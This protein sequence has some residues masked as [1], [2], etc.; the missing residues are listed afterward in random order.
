V[1]IFGG[2][3]GTAGAGVSRGAG[4]RPVVGLQSGEHY[5]RSTEREGYRNGTAGGYV[6]VGGRKVQVRRPRLCTVD[7][8]DIPLVSYPALQDAS[9]LNEAA[10]G[11]VIDGVAQRQAQESYARDQPGR[12]TPRHTGTARAALAGVGS[13]RVRRNWRRR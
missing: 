12:R 2:G 1:A 6:V 8:Q 4:L 13:R 10:L 11:K 7:G 9:L 5:E 3:P